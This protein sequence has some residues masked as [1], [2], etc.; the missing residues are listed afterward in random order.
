M[1]DKFLSLMTSA[2]TQ[3]DLFALWQRTARRATDGRLVACVAGGLVSI[4]GWVIAMLLG[5]ESAFR[6]WPGILPA[7]LV[8]AF[9]VWGI[10]DR[11]LSE[12]RGP[13]VAQPLLMVVR[14]AAALAAG[15]V[16]AISALL[17]LR[18]MLG[19]WIS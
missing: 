11:E 9:G 16:A 2:D 13:R 12:Q 5:A 15:S 17:F 10:A 6:L 4:G 7:V 14:W 1:A 8:T 3:P 19:T 18:A